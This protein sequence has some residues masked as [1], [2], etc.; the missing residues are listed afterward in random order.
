MPPAPSSRDAVAVREGRGEGGRSR[1][2][3]LHSLRRRQRQRELLEHGPKPRVGTAG[4]VLGPEIGLE[5]DTG[6]RRLYECL[7]NG[8]AV[9]QAQVD[10]SKLDRGRCALLDAS[11]QLGEIAKRLL[12]PSGER[13][14]VTAEPEDGTSIDGLV[15]LELLQRELE[16][17]LFGVLGS[18][19][20]ANRASAIAR[21]N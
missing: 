8:F 15:A 19:S 9:A 14:Q 7:E 11:L 2:A 3:L 21:S 10:L 13:K 20:M 5:R 17:T 16:L 1:H 12:P 6:L 18:R 4:L